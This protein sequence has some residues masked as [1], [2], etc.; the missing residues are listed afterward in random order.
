VAEGSVNFAPKD[1]EM[2][3]PQKEAESI[4]DGEEVP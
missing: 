4:D 2:A 3:G 1:I